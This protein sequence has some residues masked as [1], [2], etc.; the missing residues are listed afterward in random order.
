MRVDADDRAVEGRRGCATCR[1]FW[2]RRRTALRPWRRTWAAS[3]P[4]G[5]GRIARVGARVGGVI[6][7]AVF[8]MRAAELA[9]V[10]AVEVGPVAG[11][12]VEHLVGPEGERADRVARELLAP[13]GDEMG[14]GARLR[15]RSSCSSGSGRGARSRRSR[16]SWNPVRAA[17]RSGRDTHP[18]SAGPRRRARRRTCRA[19]TGT[20]GPASPGRRRGR[21]ARDPRSC[22][23]VS[24]C[25][26][27]IAG[28]PSATSAAYVGQVLTTPRCSATKTR[29][30]GANAI[31]LGWFR[32]SASDLVREARR[33]RRSGR[34]DDGH[35]PGRQES[36]DE[37]DRREQ[38][39][40]PAADR[41]GSGGRG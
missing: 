35:E 37:G 8:G 39:P 12:H 11:A 30:S 15:H 20:A 19:R 14:R 28:A 18:T 7:L 26:A 38:R 5:L 41:R 16:R 4:A 23:P 29:P 2:A 25:R 3:G 21:A 31:A 1:T 34:L 36:G 33:Q 13:V 10:G 9:P 27:L 40:D 32:P 24:G 6:G 22:R 17:S